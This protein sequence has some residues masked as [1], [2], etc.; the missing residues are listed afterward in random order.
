[1]PLFLVWVL[2]VALGVLCLW[3]VLSLYFEKP[4]VLLTLILI[5]FGTN[6]FSQ[7]IL[8]GPTANTFLFTLFLV[9]ILL[10]NAW[11]KAMHWL[12]LLLMLPVMVAIS[13]LSGAG[14]F[15]ILFPGL[16]WIPY[17][18][19]R[20]PYPV[21]RDKMKAK[22]SRHWGQLAFL[23]GIF[24]ICLVLKQFQWFC[25]PGTGFYFGDVAKADF[26]IVPANLYRVLFSVQNGWLVY[27]PLVV[28]AWAGFYLLAEK[29]PALFYAPFLFMVASLIWAASNPVWI[30][31][32]RFGYP[33]LVETYAILCLP[34]G[35]FIQWSWTRN[36]KMR[37]LMLVLSGSLVF[38][39]LF[40][41]LQFSR[42]VL[43]PGRMTQA[44]Y[45]ATLSDSLPKEPWIQCNQL[46]GYDFEVPMNDREPFRLKKA[47]HSGNYGLL[48]SPRLHYSPGM[49]IPI[50]EL[51]ER[52][53]CWI[54]ATGYF[55]FTGRNT[56]IKGFL[57]ITSIRRGKP[58][59]YKTTD[60]SEKRFLPNQWNWVEM[61]YLIPFP[62]ASDDL[63]QVYFMNYGNEDFYI[64]DVEINLCRP[65]EQP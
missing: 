62:V 45:F 47:A 58:Y 26:S 14:M 57:V 41:T 2:A 51:T 24:I 55:S 61:S 54:H 3:K 44:N 60:L 53:S 65:T 5:L 50:R 29:K 12:P 18:A 52:D 39:N 25:D 59:K 9:M 64:D 32:D 19:S 17:P 28:L 43:L 13:F 4:V 22:F 42:S 27:S 48:L 40:Q 35:Y 6:F 1:M 16:A 20:I 63:L 21:S 31:P 38:L 8:A 11:N 46:A 56:D 34:L 7:T 10:T 23:A 37:I 15:M 30:F 49:S 33:D 36:M